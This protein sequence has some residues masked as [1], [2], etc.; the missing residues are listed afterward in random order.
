MVCDGVAN[1]VIRLQESGFD[2]RK[3][4]P[5][6]RCPAHR[7]AECALSITRNEDNQV[8]LE[9]RSTQNHCLWK[10]ATSA[11]VRARFGF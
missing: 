2:P 8:L 7:S 11:R 1:V 3:V 4:S 9:C 10:P 5:D 6:L